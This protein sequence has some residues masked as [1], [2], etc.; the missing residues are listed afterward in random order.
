MAGL[1]YQIDIE[2][3][4]RENWP[5]ENSWA[6][7][8][9]RLILHTSQPPPILSLP[10]SSANSDSA[11]SHSPSKSSWVFFCSHVLALKIAPAKV[12]QKQ[13]LKLIRLFFLVFAVGRAQISPLP[14]PPLPGMRSHRGT[15]KP[16]LFGNLPNN[17]G[18]LSDA[19]RRDKGLIKYSV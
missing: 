13:C 4:L 3:I 2:Y 11:M 14:K 7:R 16:A 8:L 6:R 5:T 1:T 17:Y 19:P 12:S 18:N 10:A 15:G 9:T